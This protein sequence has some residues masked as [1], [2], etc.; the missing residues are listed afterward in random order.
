[1]FLDR[2]KIFV[3][4]G[5]GG[6]GAATFRREAHVPRGGPGRRRRRPRRVDRACASMPARPPSATSATSTISRPTPA[7]AARGSRRHGKA[8]EDL[9]LTVP[10]GTAVYDD[11]TGELLADLVAAGQAARSRAAA[12]AA[13]ATPTSRPPPTRPP[14][15]PRRASPGEERWLRLELRL[16]ADVGLV[17]L[18][19]RGQ[20]DAARGPHRGH[21]EDR[22]LPVHDPRA[23]PGRARPRAMRATTRRPD[24][25]RRARAHRGRQ[26]RARAWATRSCATSSGPGSW[27]TSS[28][29]RRA[30][31]NG[32]TASSATSSRRTIRRCSSKPTLVAFNKID[33]PR[34]PRRVA[35]VPGGP[36]RE[37]QPTVVAISAATRRGA[38]RAAGGARRAAAA[39]RGARRAARAGRASSSTG[40]RRRD[41]ASTSSAR[42]TASSASRG[43]RI[44]RLA[45]QT[46][47]ENEESA[48][49]FQR[50][51]ARL[52]IDAELRRAGV[53]ARRHGPHRH[54]RAGVGAAEPWEVGRPASA[55]SWHAGGR[56]L[57][58]PGRDVRPDP[59]R[60]PRDRRSRPRGSSASSGSCSCRPAQPPHQ[61][62]AAGRLGGGPRWRWSAWRSPATRR[63][64]SSRIELDR[65]GPSYTVDTLDDAGSRAPCRRRRLD[66]RF[67]LSAEAFAGFPTLARARAASSPWPAWRWC[68]RA[69]HPARTTPGSRRAAVAAR[70]GS[71]FVDGPL[72][73]ISASVVRGRAA[74]GSLRP[75][76]RPGGGRGLHRATIGSTL[77]HRAGPAMPAAT[78]PDPD[79]DRSRPRRREPRPRTADGHAATATSR[80]P[81]AAEPAPAA[82]RR[83]GGARASPARIVELAEDKKAADIV[84]LDLDRADDHG[85]L[86]S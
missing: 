34:P 63:S 7:V 46:D 26:P 14:S 4:A 3:R 60:P 86:P 11:A 70:G 82:A 64:R 25:R 53:R 27:S 38:A 5:D 37:R 45:A 52:G 83:A 79:A 50:D 30:T 75:L 12:G 10:P 16:I 35:G 62:G 22:R 59:P 61:A 20:V 2:V 66:L 69:G 71:T 73:P 39:G 19:E 57:G 49:R 24:D 65:A 72:L 47:F 78:D 6:D 67:I 85:R 77:S 32:T 54:D 18:P 33:L 56:P 1:M 8:G 29:A 51:L 81:T 76:P 13:S 40:S 55:R 9:V 31:R 36:R 84:L 28:T 42:R 23:Q 41:E 68:P 48:E 44:E 74:A 80:A 17:G 15:T 58:D 43:R 21:A